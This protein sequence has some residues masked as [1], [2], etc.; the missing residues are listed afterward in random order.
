MISLI[1]G[2]WVSFIARSFLFS[3]EL[4]LISLIHIWADHRGK[5]WKK[6]FGKL[7]SSEW[8]LPWP[9]QWPAPPTSSSSS[10]RAQCT[11]ILT[12]GFKAASERW[13][14]P[15]LPL[16]P[17]PS[18]VQLT[19]LRK[20]GTKWCDA[21]ASFCAGTVSS[22]AASD[23][24]WRTS[25]IVDIIL[26]QQGEKKKKKKPLKFLQ[27]ENWHVSGRGGGKQTAV[28]IV[29][30]LAL[31]KDKGG[32]EVFQPGSGLAE[33]TIRELWT[34]EFQKPPREM[35]SRMSLWR[36][37]PICMAMPKTGY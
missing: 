20:Q 12:V 4:N 13:H 19:E 30:C 5:D 21:L 34:Q 27:H 3:S 14:H 35:P 18:W 1:M 8:S 32:I 15:S 28:D 17:W 23:P 33:G 7:M 31:W 9:L 26:M 37:K 6:D 11:C 36:F 29:S 2:N 22:F 25:R 10:S 16:P 24:C